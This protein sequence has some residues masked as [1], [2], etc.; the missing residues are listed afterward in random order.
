MFCAGLFS[1]PNKLVLKFTL[2]Y[3]SLALS[4]CFFE[5]IRIYVLASVHFGA[6]SM[7]INTSLHLCRTA[8]QLLLAQRS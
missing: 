3:Q 4:S 7:S 1:E 6:K 8:L 2:F 5:K